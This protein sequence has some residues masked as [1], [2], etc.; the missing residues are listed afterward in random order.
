MGSTEC[1][2]DTLEDA[3]YTALRHAV[4]A[5]TVISPVSPVTGGRNPHISVRKAARRREYAAYIVLHGPGGIGTQTLD[6]MIRDAVKT[7]G[8]VK[9]ISTTSSYGPGGF[10]KHPHVCAEVLFSTRW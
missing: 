8:D 3:L 9:T 2:S 1:P 5:Y 6:F 10:G 7:I 4:P